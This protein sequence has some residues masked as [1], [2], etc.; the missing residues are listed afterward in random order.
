MTNRQLQE[1]GDKCPNIPR[2][3][4]LGYKFIESKVYRESCIVNVFTEKVC[5]V[6]VLETNASALVK[7][8]AIIRHFDLKVFIFQD[9]NIE[10]I[11]QDNSI[12]YQVL[13]KT[14]GVRKKLKL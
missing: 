11:F 13:N 6:I 2:I 9:Q 7:I 1:K 5:T 8:R 3:E 4:S 12:S 14:I 10:Y